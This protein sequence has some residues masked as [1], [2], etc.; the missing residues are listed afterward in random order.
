MR[1]YKS[2][3]ARVKAEYDGIP[4]QL[5][6]IRYGKST[7]YEVILTTDMTLSFKEAFERYQIRWNME[8][9]F[10]ES[11]QHL[12]LGRC[13]STDLNAQVADCTLAFIGYSVI[14]LH[15]RFTDYE[16]F[17]ELFRDIREG[18]L[19]LTFIERLLPIIAELLEKIA[20]LFNS[21]LDD[22]LEKALADEETKHDLECI[23]RYNP[24]FKERL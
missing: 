19:E 6:F 3:Y 8:V 5:F 2:S 10:Y 24:N 12:E 17:G 22:L 20:R 1:Q 7:Q 15:K 18:L 9:L 13:Q 14:S 4:I 23:L 11:K 16:T 21:T